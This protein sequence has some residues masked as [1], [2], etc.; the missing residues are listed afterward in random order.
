MIAEYKA[1]TNTRSNKPT[2]AIGNDWEKKEY[3]G[4]ITIILMP[5]CKTTRYI[6]VY[7]VF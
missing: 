3:L 4:S 7:K 6:Y 1:A 2:A 5:I